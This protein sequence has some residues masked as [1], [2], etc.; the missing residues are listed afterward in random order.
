VTSH[1]SSSTFIP[2]DDTIIDLPGVSTPFYSSS[3]HPLGHTDELPR[4]VLN[5]GSIS[6]RVQYMIEVLMQVHKDKYKDNPILP[7]GLDLVEG[8]EQITHETQ[9]EKDLKVKD[10]LSMYSICYTTFFLNGLTMTGDGR[11]PPTI[12]GNGQSPTTTPEGLDLVE[13]EEQITHEIQL[14][15][16][17]EVEDGLCTYSICYTSVLFKWSDDAG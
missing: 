9:L 1:R 4:A 13:E 2:Y 11:R 8:E 14:E 5:E 6:H 3:H 17:L 16:D 7:E 15:K 10:G 12:G